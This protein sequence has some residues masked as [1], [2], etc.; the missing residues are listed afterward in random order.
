MPGGAERVSRDEVASMA[1]KTIE[2][3]ER[4]RQLA[5]AENHRVA[6]PILEELAALGYQVSSF[7]ELRRSGRYES[8]LPVFDLVDAA[9]RER[10]HSDGCR[11]IAVRALREP[12]AQRPLIEAYHRAT[13]ETVKWTI[14][15]GLDVLADRNSR[16][17]ARVRRYR[18]SVRAR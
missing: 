17:D 18:A 2:E 11:A 1:E 13:D 7:F 8:A 15:N 5:V 9:A 6:K 4:E 12:I 16:D 10:G 3:R 14:G